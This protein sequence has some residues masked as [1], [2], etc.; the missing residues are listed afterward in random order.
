MEGIIAV[1]GFWAVILALVLKRP[2]N[3]LV[4]AFVTH[5][6]QPAKTHEIEELKSKVAELENQISGMTMQMIE[7]RDSHDFAF[8]LLADSEKAKKKQS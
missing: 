8:K 7:M 5:R 1:G 2:I 4:Q 3:D 6:M